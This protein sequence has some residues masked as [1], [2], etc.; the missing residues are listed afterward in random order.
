MEPGWTYQR[1]MRCAISCSEGRCPGRCVVS[2]LQGVFPFSED[3]FG[4]G[5]LINVR[6]E[7]CLIFSVRSAASF[8]A[9][10]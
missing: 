5:P 10:K 6:S 4:G 9:C 2:M 3:P 1:T 8:S 7:A